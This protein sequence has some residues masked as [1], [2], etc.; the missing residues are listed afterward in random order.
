MPNTLKP[1]VPAGT[2]NATLVS[3][4]MGVSKTNAPM[5]EVSFNIASGAYKNETITMKK[6]LHGTRNDAGMIANTLQ[7][8]KSLDSGVCVAFRDYGDFG[9]VISDVA[10]MTR[11]KKFSLDYNPERFIPIHVQGHKIRESA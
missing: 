9:C 6:V 5:M 8:L 11:T 2:Y 7:F 1:A 10:T 3:L 4:E